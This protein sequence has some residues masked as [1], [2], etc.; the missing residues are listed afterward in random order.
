LPKKQKGMNTL[1]NNRPDPWLPWINVLAYLLILAVNYLANSLPLGGQTTG[2]VARQYDNLLLPSGYV[3]SIWGVIYTGLGVFVFWQ[4][5]KGATQ[6][7]IRQA[8][9]W[10]FPLSAL[11][12]A[13]WLWAWHTAGPA[14]SI[15]LM[16]LYFIS[17]FLIYT[18]LQDRCEGSRKCALIVKLPFSIL[19]AWLSFALIANL[20]AFLVSIGYTGGV[21]GEKA[22]TGLIL[23][24]SFLLALAFL[25]RKKDMAAA[26]TFV[27]A[28]SGLISRHYGDPALQGL[29][30]LLFLISG[31]TLLAA[32]YVALRP[33]L[34]RGKFSASTSAKEKGG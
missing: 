20:T 34:R 11:F 2:E 26:L 5:G 4:L 8:V 10:F 32:L 24:L 29:I 9:S 31:L 23:S 16:L 6:Q 19:L 17:V 28:W 3:F 22:W 30:L 25:W 15:K 18:R 13:G 21:W 14:L 7:R 1:T 12:N 27:W 33:A